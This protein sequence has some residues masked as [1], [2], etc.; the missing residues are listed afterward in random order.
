MALVRNRN[1]INAMRLCYLLTHFNGL[2]SNKVKKSVFTNVIWS[3]KNF[4]RRH[5]MYNLQVKKFKA[6]KKASND[7]TKT[8][9]SCDEIK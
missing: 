6:N 3:Y 8:L 5:G 2:F 1:M 7:I 4:E 9:D